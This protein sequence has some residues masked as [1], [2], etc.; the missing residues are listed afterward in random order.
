MPPPPLPPCGLNSVVTWLVWRERSR[1]PY[2]IVGWLWFLGTLVPVIGL[3]KAGSL[4]LADRYTY[5]PLI[6]IFIALAFGVQE[7]TVRFSR[8]KQPMVIASVII[9]TACVALTERQLQF[10]HDSET[11]FRHEPGGEPHR[12]P[13]A[14]RLLGAALEADGQQ[15]EALA[16]YRETIRL[17]DDNANAHDDLRQ[18]AV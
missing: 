3:V 10:W 13:C 14:S 1:R 5:F 17:A 2:L 6:G 16:E 18:S 15:T 12:F 9:L 8:L 4:A 7:L 11:L